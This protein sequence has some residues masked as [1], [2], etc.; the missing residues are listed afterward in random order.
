[1]GEA[2]DYLLEIRLDEGPIDETDAYER[3]SVWARRRGIEPVR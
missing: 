2:L 1:V 3:L